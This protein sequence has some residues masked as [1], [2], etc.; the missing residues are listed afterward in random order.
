MSFLGL[1]ICG[2][3]ENQFGGVPRYHMIFYSEIKKKKMFFLTPPQSLYCITSDFSCSYS[4]SWGIFTLQHTDGTKTAL[5][6]LILPVSTPSSVGRKKKHIFKILISIQPKIINI[7]LKRLLSNALDLVIQTAA[8]PKS[9]L[10]LKLLLR[11]FNWVLIPSLP[12]FEHI[13]TINKLFYWWP[14]FC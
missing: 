3:C 10:T 11:N 1:P 5:A 4:C 14:Q 8:F 6:S 13:I 7:L 12:T 9:C 2:K